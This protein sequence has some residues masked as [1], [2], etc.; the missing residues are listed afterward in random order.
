LEE[1]GRLE[2]KKALGIMKKIQNQQD[3]VARASPVT[4]ED[5][6]LSILAM[7]EDGSPNQLVTPIPQVPLAADTFRMNQKEL[8]DWMVNT[9]TKGWIFMKKAVFLVGKAKFRKSMIANSSTTYVNI[10]KRRCHK[11]LGMVEDHCPG[12]AARKQIQQSGKQC[13]KG[14]VNLCVIMI[15]G[16]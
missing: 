16:R 1:S 6:M 8:E 5:F 4:S 14:V 12:I 13:H 9:H 10:Y 7:I 11:V 2:L 15:M 3:F